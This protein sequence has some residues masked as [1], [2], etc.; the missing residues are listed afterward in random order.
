MMAGIEFTE[1][2][3]YTQQ[4]SRRWREFFVKNPETLDSPF[5][6][7]GSVRALVEHIFTVELHFA[8]LVSGSEHA[9]KKNGSVASLDEIFAIGEEAE[10]KYRQIFADPAIDWEEMLDLGF[11]GLRASRRKMVTQALTHSLRH[12]AQIA[13]FLRQQ[14]FKQD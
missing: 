5:D 12:W 9:A 11:R 13:T 10:G 1:L 8:N 6:V 7:T 4:E 14:G 2:L 3:A